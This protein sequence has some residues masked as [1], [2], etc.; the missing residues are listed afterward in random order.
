MVVGFMAS[1][2]GAEVA[3]QFGRQGLDE[4]KQH[5]QHLCINIVKLKLHNNNYL[6]GKL[7]AEGSRAFSRHHCQIAKTVL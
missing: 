3:G 5:I 7:S 4:S 6:H 2:I 1:A